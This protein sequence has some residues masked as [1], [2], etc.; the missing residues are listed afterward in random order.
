MKSLD[1]LVEVLKRLGVIQ[2]KGD[3]GKYCAGDP[4]SDENAVATISLWEDIISATANLQQRIL[5]DLYELRM[6]ASGYEEK[7]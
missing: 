6:Y 5:R 2:E 7:E 4:L 3:F 1:D